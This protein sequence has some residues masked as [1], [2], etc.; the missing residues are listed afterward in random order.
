V[1]SVDPWNV[2]VD[3]RVRDGIL[4]GKYEKINALMQDDA[5]YAG[6]SLW[7][8]I[9]QT[10]GRKVI[11][12]IL[13]LSIIHRNI[14]NGFTYILGKNLG[15][16]QDGWYRYYSSRYNKS[17]FDSEDEEEEPFLKAPKGYIVTHMASSKN[18]RYLA[19]V[20]QKFSEYKLYIYDFQEEDRDRIEKGGY[21]IAQNAD[22]SYP[23]LS[24]HPN[25]E[26]LAFFTEEK[27]FIYLNF[28]N[29]EKD[30]LEKKTFFKFDK[31]L[32]FD[33]SKDGK[34]FLLSAV[35]NGQS[36]IFIYTILNTKIEQLTNDSY[37]DLY[38]SFF[39][40]DKRVI[41]SSN[42]FTDTLKQGEFSTKFSNQ[43]DLFA[44]K[45]KEPE[46]TSVIWRMTRSP[47]INELKAEEYV[48]SYIS[49]MSNRG[50]AQNRHLIQI[51]S[52]IAYVDTVTHYEYSFKEYQVTHY[53][54]NLLANSFFPETDKTLNLFFKDDR[55]KLFSEP[56]L[57]PEQ[58]NLKQVSKPIGQLEDTSG[59]EVISQKDNFSSLY[60]P[61]VKS[62]DFEVDIDNYRFN[63]ESSIRGKEEDKK[64]K[65][66]QEPEAVQIQPVPEAITN[67]SIEKEELQI[68]P[69]RNYFLSFYQDDFS[70]SFGNAFINPQYQRFTG[71]VSGDLLNSGFNMNFKI[72]AIELMHDYRLIG[73]VRTSFQPLSGTSLAPN[74]EFIVGLLDYK[75]RLDKEYI[76]TRRSQV[77]FISVADY[78][79]I[80]T[81]EV[82]IKLSWP[83]N[84]VASI[85]GD[86]GYRMD[87]TINLSREQNSLERPD[88]YQNYT[89]A[90]LAYVYDNTRKIGTNLH[91]GLRYKLFFEY[92]YNLNTSPSGLYNTGLD[93]RQ[94]TIIHRNLIWANRLATGFSFGPQKLIYFM[95]GVDNQ[96]APNFDPTTRIATENN[97]IFQTL[98]TNMRGFFQNVRNGNKFALINSEIRWPIFSYLANKPLRSDFF[99]NFQVLF[100]GDLGTAWNG[101]SPYS[102]ENAINTR[103]EDF[104]GLK[105]VLD[106]QKE[107]I[108][109]A[110][111]VGV[112]SRL[113]G[114]YVRV[115]LAWGVEDGIILPRVWH[116]SLGTDF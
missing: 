2:E 110:Y 37:N 82:T 5:R 60:Y 51:D 75:K 20:C 23:I 17:E 66:A 65:E 68:P 19:Y 18:G 59:T 108:I 35:K 43:H 109:G 83:F 53:D 104:G 95:G 88:E 80:I 58:L 84:P 78:Q 105:V 94:Y 61:G 1:V 11:K 93:L 25:N 27:G 69:K 14:E 71:F 52:S 7:Y 92:F 3:T 42:R 97:Y 48:P 56:F 26:I 112:R 49:F 12:N 86:I 6:H 79:R 101:P 96:F 73:G 50:K 90:R 99:K 72:G 106:S 46:D 28:Y 38:P 24:W 100:F 4:T 89:I 54:R 8:Y 45:A 10:Y 67:L 113:F 39:D 74:A 30:E 62:S 63:N 102:Q 13:Y 64:E 41:F 91:A 114:Y 47:G 15:D 36:D 98:A 116:I 70:T 9:D 81:H 111:G 115:D 21:K 22:Y 40:N 31:I 34:Q 33:Y 16:I 29:L 87:R 57:Y 44:M 85:R 107:P 76:Y 55:Y 32:S 103:I 77:Q